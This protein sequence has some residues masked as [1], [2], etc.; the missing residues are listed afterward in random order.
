MRDTDSTNP[1]D[2]NDD[3]AE[4]TDLMRVQRE[5]DAT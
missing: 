1:V 2:R 3:T 5:I 4:F